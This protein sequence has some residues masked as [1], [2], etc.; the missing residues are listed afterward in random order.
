MELHSCVI[1]SGQG[2]AVVS[3]IRF[4]S[5]QWA[6]TVLAIAFAHVY[7]A[8]LIGPI[9]SIYRNYKVYKRAR[10]VEGVES[11]DRVNKVD[12]RPRPN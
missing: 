6:A 2:L 1:S 5:C 12:P 9:K 7:N 11:V 4:L 8:F 3:P 10:G